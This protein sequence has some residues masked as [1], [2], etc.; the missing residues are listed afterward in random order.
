MSDGDVLHDAYWEAI[1]LHAQWH[2]AIFFF[3]GDQPLSGWVELLEWRLKE[4]I[5]LGQRENAAYLREKIPEIQTLWRTLQADARAQVARAERG[6][7]IYQPSPPLDLSKPFVLLATARQHLASMRSDIP[8]YEALLDCIQRFSSAIIPAWQSTPGHEDRD[9]VP[10]LIQSET[11]AT[12]T[13]HRW[14]ASLDRLE[15]LLISPQH[16]PS[17]IQHRYCPA[18]HQAL[19]NPDLT[20][21]LPRIGQCRTLEEF[22]TYWE[23]L[24]YL[25]GAL[26]GWAAP[27][28]GL[29]WWYAGGKQ[30][31]GDPRLDLINSLWDDGGQLDYV[32]AHCWR[33]GVCFS[34]PEDLSPAEMAVTSPWRDE[35][36]WRQFKRQGRRYAEDPFYGGTNPLH[37][38]LFSC[39]GSIPPENSS[40][41]FIHPGPDRTATLVVEDFASWHTALEDFGNTLPEDPHRSWHV[42]VFHKPGGYLGLFRRSRVTGRWFQGKHRVH[43][44]G[45]PNGM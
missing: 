43:M 44:A 38:D 36:W 23:T 32:A 34:D 14:L 28:A 31:Q 4:T 30:A 29:A 12:D 33:G 35:D 8:H 41:G 3:T 6:D 18:L 17:M 7:L 16:H 11:I 10:N 19:A 2:H 21:R 40:Q 39:G 42:D 20:D 1:A 22:Q 27:D 26:L 37:L 15:A 5:S 25:M 24:F 13:F 9:F 45:N